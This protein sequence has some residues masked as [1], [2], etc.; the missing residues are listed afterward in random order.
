MVRRS[1]RQVFRQ[2]HNTSFPGVLNVLIFF[3]FTD[4]IRSNI[5][6]NTLSHFPTIRRTLL[7]FQPCSI[8]SLVSRNRR[9]V[10]MPH[11]K[12]FYLLWRTNSPPCF[13]L[14]SQNTYRIPFLI[15]IKSHFG[16]PKLYLN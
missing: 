4:I 6:Y 15:S 8:Y 9:I 13:S 1:P 16:N 5:I 2:L 12:L 10:K 3:P 7:F 14:S 11:N